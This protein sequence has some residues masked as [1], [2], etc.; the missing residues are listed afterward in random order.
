MANEKP[1]Y[2]NRSIGSV[3][4]LAQCLGVSKARLLTISSTA[5]NSYTEFSRTTI[6]N[7]KTKERILNEPKAGLKIIQKKINR[8]IFEGI[9]YPDYLHGGLKERDYVS[10]VQAHAG[11][12]T[13]IGLDI[14]DFYPSIKKHHVAEIFK[15]LFRFDTDVC[16]ILVNLTTKNGVVTQGGCCSSYIANLIFFNAEFS[17]VSKL[18]AKGY[19]YTRL[20]DDITISSKSTIPK[21]KSETI[22]SEIS[23][24]FTKFKLELN[25]EKTKV[26]HACDRTADFEITGLWAAHGNPKLKKKDRRYVRQLVHICTKEYKKDPFS[27]DFHS[28]WNRTSGKVAVLT[29]LQHAQAKSLRLQLSKCLPL[30]DDD[31]SKK[32]Q[33]L[34]YKLCEIPDL[35]TGSPSKLKVYRKLR[36]HFGIVARN[37]KITAK[38]W[39]LNLDSKF[40]N[41]A[42]IERKNRI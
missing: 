3:D 27:K 14:K 35:D 19:C 29:R 22:I 1:Y 36:Y 11:A 17:K 37:D 31:A 30:Y 23:G 26:E 32:L 13:I 8:E 4:A 24:L 9:V 16:E 7:G 39:K 20:L 34:A 5:K 10:N 18:R 12:R 21:E 6:K 28:L 42:E 40:K 2:R 33:R 15:N 38:R 25:R 41:S